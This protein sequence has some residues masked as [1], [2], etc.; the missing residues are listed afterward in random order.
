[1]HKWVELLNNFTSISD[2]SM[3]YQPDCTQ[4]GILLLGASSVPIK[5]SFSAASSNC[6]DERQETR[7][8]QSSHCT[9]MR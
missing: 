5:S 4:E 7:A 2:I 6:K 9:Q 3:T 1:M 8:G